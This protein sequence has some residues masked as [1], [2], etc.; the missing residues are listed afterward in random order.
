MRKLTIPLFRFNELELEARKKAIKGI[1]EI[2]DPFEVYV[3]DFEKS[4]NGFVETMGLRFNRYACFN[5]SI[6]PVVS[7]NIVFSETYEI[8][9]LNLR[10]RRLQKWLYN[11]F[12]NRVTQGKYYGKVLC[13]EDKA[14][15]RYCRSVFRESRIIADKEACVFSGTVYDTYFTGPIIE[16]ISL[17]NPNEF[18]S[19]EGIIRDALLSGF[20]AFKE[21]IEYYRSDEGVSE[22]IDAND[23]EFLKDGTFYKDSLM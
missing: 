13:E 20:T 7:F 22:Y 2:Y 1:S 4:I 16:F 11:N 17:R 14:G 19:V 18:V 3:G 21:D 10:G 15:R 23:F 5:W 12:W 6:D 8:H 9:E